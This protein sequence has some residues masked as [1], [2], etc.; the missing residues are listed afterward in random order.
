MC[1]KSGQEPRLKLQAMR[2]PSYEGLKKEIRTADPTRLDA[3]YLEKNVLKKEKI[4]RTK[5]RGWFWSLEDYYALHL[6]LYTPT[7]LPMM[8]RPGIKS[9]LY[10]V[11]TKIATSLAHSSELTYFVSTPKQITAQLRWTK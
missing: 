8:P 2:S 1:R 6:V 3:S 4:K 5:E 11:P 7:S 10:V 9:L